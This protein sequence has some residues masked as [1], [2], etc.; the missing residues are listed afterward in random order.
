MT[1][2]DN[3]R[4]VVYSFRIARA[5]S[6]YM[7]GSRAAD[8]K[9]S[10]VQ[11]GYQGEVTLDV[12][13]NRVLRLKASADDIPKESDV[14]QSSVEVDYSFIDVGG[15]SYLLPSRSVALMKR[16]YRTIGNTVN[17]VDYKKFEADSSISFKE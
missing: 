17:F 3:R 2:I 6:H 12:A 1:E 7:V 4:A 15:K 8:G 11:A 16:G 14:T 5:K 13:T 9:L 10:P